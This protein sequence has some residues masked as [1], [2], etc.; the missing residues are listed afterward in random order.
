MRKFLNSKTRSKAV[1]GLIAL[2]LT[3]SIILS[4]FTG[5]FA[6]AGSQ[7]VWDGSTAAGF[8]SGTGTATDPY[9][10]ENGA[11]L[12]YLISLGDA[13]A[14][15]FYKLAADIY[16][17]DTTVANWYT[18]S[19]LNEWPLLSA[20]DATTAF[21]GTFYGDGHIVHGLYVEE[22]KAHSNNDARDVAE[23]AGLFPVLAGGATID[24]VG[25]ENA[26]VKIT[27]ACTD[28]KANRSGVAGAIAGSYVDNSAAAPITIT[29]CYAADTVKLTACIAGF[30]GGNVSNNSGTGVSITNCY[31]LLSWDVNTIASQDEN[32]RSG[33]I[34]YYGNSATFSGC[35]GLGNV[36]GTLVNKG[37]V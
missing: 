32:A 30:I 16:L 35:F 7:D 19:G 21:K 26:Y 14:G 23:A 8:A 36:A 29:R 12:R 13:T 27:N 5:L 4:T 15:K 2:V 31:N 37:A 20:T 24:A 18:Q 1:T 25:V 28:A 17:N 6:S 9:I 3:L 33:L 34:A 22:V 10:I 11:Q